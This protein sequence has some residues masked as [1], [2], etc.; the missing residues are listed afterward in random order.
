MPRKK[1]QI[2]AEYRKAGFSERAG[3]GDHIVY[4]H[5]LLREHYVVAG[6]DGKDALLYDERN[7]QRALRAL[8]DARKKQSGGQ[9]P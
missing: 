5:P 3:K 9:Q 6:A 4:W 1:R 8:D 2:R 7:L